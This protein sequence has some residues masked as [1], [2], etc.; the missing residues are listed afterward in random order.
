MPTKSMT[1]A[2]LVATVHAAWVL[3]QPLFEVLVAYFLP[4][5]Q[6]SILHACGRVRRHAWLGAGLARRVGGAEVL[7]RALIFEGPQTACLGVLL[8]TV[9]G[10][11]SSQT[12]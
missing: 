4:S 6:C 7:I 5:L 3:K 10:L 1:E 2:L 11:K 8:T 9:R 12:P